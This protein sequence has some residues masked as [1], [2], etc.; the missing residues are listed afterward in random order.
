M[1]ATKYRVIID[2]TNPNITAHDLAAVGSLISITY[3]DGSNP[4]LWNDNTPR[5]AWRVWYEGEDFIV[6]ANEPIAA[7]V[8]LLQSLG[9]VFPDTKQ[10]PSPGEATEKGFSC[11]YSSHTGGFM[12]TCKPPEG[13][14]HDAFVSAKPFPLVMPGDDADMPGG[15]DNGAA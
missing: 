13:D 9:L 5:K 1:Q 4:A 10:L 14:S 12:I 11:H 15:H 6:P 7:G 8:I 2:V 3:Q